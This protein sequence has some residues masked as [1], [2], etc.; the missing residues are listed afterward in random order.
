MESWVLVT[1]GIARNRGT[2]REIRRRGDVGSGDMWG[3]QE[4]RSRRGDVE[5]LGLVPGGVARN[6]DGDAGTGAWENIEGM[7]RK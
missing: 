3:C 1:C 7:R 4:Q 5:M 6:R 2:V